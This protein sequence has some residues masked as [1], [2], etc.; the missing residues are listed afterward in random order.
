M[1][2]FSSSFLQGQAMFPTKEI[3]FTGLVYPATPGLL[4]TASG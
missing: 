2:R 4:P 3:D 1:P